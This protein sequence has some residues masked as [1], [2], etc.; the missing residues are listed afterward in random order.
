MYLFPFQNENLIY[1]LVTSLRIAQPL[2][3]SYNL[4]ESNATSR[5][6]SQLHSAKSHERHNIRR[7]LVL[8]RKK[9]IFKTVRK[10]FI[11]LE[12]FQTVWKLSTLSGNFPDWLETFQT[13]LTT[14]LTLWKL[15]R[16]SR[17]IPDCKETFQTL[18]K[19]SR[20]LGSFPDFLDALKHSGRHAAEVF[21][22][23][24]YTSSV[25]I[26]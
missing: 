3:R 2:I 19:L 13:H 6:V 11:L 14:F 21:G 24:I 10:L 9:D 17:N 22:T 1:S 26:N 18:R 16:F 15:S 23:L 20:L 25:L 7:C 8:K 4:S 12:T 5:A